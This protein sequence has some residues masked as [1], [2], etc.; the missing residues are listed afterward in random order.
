MYSA[1][2]RQRAVASTKTANYTVLKGDTGT[3]FD[4]AGAAATITFTLP[5][6][7]VG[8][9]YSFCTVAAQSIVVTPGGSDTIGLGAKA[10]GASI[11]SAA[12]KGAFLTLVCTSANAWTITAISSTPAWT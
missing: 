4:N 5:A 10:A 7:T 11:T 6:A 3:V 8:Q 9:V 12:S 2:K 1:L